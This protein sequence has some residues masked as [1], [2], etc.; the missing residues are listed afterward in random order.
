MPKAR[1]DRV[2][3]KSVVERIDGQTI[4]LEEIRSQGRATIEALEA[5]RLAL[6]ARLSSAITMGRRLVRTGRSQ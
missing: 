6:E 2:S 3:L 1:R 5:V 4:I